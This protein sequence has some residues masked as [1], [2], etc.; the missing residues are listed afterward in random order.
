MWGHAGHVRP[1]TMWVVYDHPRDYPDAFVARRWEI[2]PGVMIATQD[3]HTAATLEAVRE[4]I[5][6]GLYRINRD[7][8]DEP[9]IVEVW[10]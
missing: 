5:P 6:P 9:Q 4:R 1:L 3:A 2:A 7:Q 10:V 8:N